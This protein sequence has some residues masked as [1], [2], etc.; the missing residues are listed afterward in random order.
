MKIA[1]NNCYGGFSVSEDVYSELGMVWDGYGYLDNKAFG[2]ESDN[3]LGYRSHH[4]L[5]SAIE[6]IGDKAASGMF[7]EILIVDIPD[8]VEWEIY[9]YDGIETVHEK[10]RSW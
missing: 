6:K 8:G 1:I 9:E 4:K 7:A 10:H 5:I 2:V 3:Y